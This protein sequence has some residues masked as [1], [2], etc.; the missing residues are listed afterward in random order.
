MLTRYLRRAG[1]LANSA[2]SRATIVDRDV[3]DGE[4][5][6]CWAGS[7]ARPSLNAV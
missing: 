2:P 3:L 6:R 7:S 1:R 5:R 4:R